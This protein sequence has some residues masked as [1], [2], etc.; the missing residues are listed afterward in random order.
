MN[1]NFMR[2]RSIFLLIGGAELLFAEFAFF[3]GVRRRCASFAPIK[4]RRRQTE[5][6]QAENC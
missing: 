5:C 4:K 1:I 6:K 3:F 2:C